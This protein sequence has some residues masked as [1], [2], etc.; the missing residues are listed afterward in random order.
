[1]KDTKG[2]ATTVSGFI[3]NFLR[4][5]VVHIFVDSAFN[6]KLEVTDRFTSLTAV[7]MVS[8]VRAC[9]NL[10]DRTLNM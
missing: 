10:S 2:Y 7:V 4:F 3:G 8:W 1:M 5:P 9:Q 6:F